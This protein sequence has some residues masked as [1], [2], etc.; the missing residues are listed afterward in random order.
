MTHRILGYSVWG[1]PI[2]CLQGGR[3]SRRVLLCAAFH[4]SEW[5]TERLLLRFWAEFSRREDLQRCARVW[6]VPCVNPDGVAV[7]RGELTAAER[8]FACGVAGGEPL[9]YWKANGRGVDLNLNY[10]AGWERAVEIKRLSAPAARNWPG[11]HPLSEP[12]SRIMAELA[13]RVRPDVMVTL[14]AQGEEIYWQ[15]DGIEPPDAEAMGEEMARRSGY[16]LAEVPAESAYAGYK[17]WFLRRFKKPAYT[18]ECG[19]GE[20]PLPLQQLD[21]IGER[22][23]P[24]LETALTFHNG[25]WTVDKGGSKGPLVK[26][27]CQRS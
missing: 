24:I 7:S 22:V 2:V 18:V 12:E 20:N 21:A 3:G 16:R 25:D 26:G 19:L 8:R 5:I 4:G 23:M 10:P 17:D 13:C 6:A 9:R 11:P 27:G 14:H 15:Y 1:R